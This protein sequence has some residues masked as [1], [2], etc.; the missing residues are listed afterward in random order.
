M[1]GEFKFSELTEFLPKTIT[2]L[3]GEPASGKTNICLISTIKVAKT[4]KSV[5]YVDTEGSFSTQ[6][7]K[8]IAGKDSAELL[9]LIVVAEP[10]DFDEQKIAINKIE[11]LM[12]DRDVGLIVVDSLVSLYRLEMGSTS[13]PYA[14]N[15]ELSKQLAKLMK[16]AK[17]YNIPILV[18]NQVYSTFNKEGKDSKVVPVGRDVLRYWTKNVINIK[19]DGQT[20]IAEVMRHKFKPEGEKLRFKITEEG[21]KNESTSDSSS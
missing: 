12:P 2:Q 7:F 15:R 20:R 21:I 9:K 8:Q 5:V 17:K 13:D 6:R 4:G 19:K 18:T 11:D 1:V 10:S 16:M 3:Y 14:T